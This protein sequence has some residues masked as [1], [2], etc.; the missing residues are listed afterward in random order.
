MFF[1]VFSE[2]SLLVGTSGLLV[3]GVVVHCR[4]LVFFLRFFVLRDLILSMSFAIGPL[5]VGHLLIL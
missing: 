4:I 3:L 1:V 2:G 5:L